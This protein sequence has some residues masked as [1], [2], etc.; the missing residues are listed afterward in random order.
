VRN[1]VAE[2]AA[3]PLTIDAFV[4]T[5]ATFADRTDAARVDFRCR[6]QQRR[7]VFEA[8]HPAATLVLRL[9]DV[10]LPAAALAD[11]QPLPRL[12]RDRLD[13]ADQGWMVEGRTTI[14]KARARELRAE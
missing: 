13:G 10:D 11:G 7:M 6:R 9:Q 1:H 4:T 5:E 3:D 14:L 2:R 12:D 8:S